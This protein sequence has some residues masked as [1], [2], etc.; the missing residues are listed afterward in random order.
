MSEKT[1]VALT[2]I[3]T[4]LD[5]YLPY[6]SLAETDELLNMLRVFLDDKFD[7]LRQKEKDMEATIGDA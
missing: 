2:A 3:T 4:G 6:L 7:E 5:S 1:K